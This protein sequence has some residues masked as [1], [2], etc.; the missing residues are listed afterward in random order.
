MSTLTPEK[1]RELAATYGGS[2]A[3]TGDTRV[4]IAL[5]S[6]RI[7]DLTEHLRGAKKDHA[8]RRGLL[9]LVGRRRRLL[10]YL[11][12]S[13]LEAYRELVAALGLRK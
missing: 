2:E 13:N 5:L 12:S 8:S 4:Q 1:T 6:Q 3:N 9:M 10:N 7:E 11:Q